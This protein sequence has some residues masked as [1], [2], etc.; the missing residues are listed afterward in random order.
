M[1]AFVE[2]LNKL[3]ILPFKR[4]QV[5]NS[6]HRPTQKQM[7]STSDNLFV[8]NKHQ[9][10]RDNVAVGAIYG[11]LLE[12]VLMNTDN[13]KDGWD[14]NDKCPSNNPSEGWDGR[15]SDDYRSNSCSNDYS[16]SS[17]SSDS[18]SSSSSDSSW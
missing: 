6:T 12:Q 2:K 14:G 17:S 1:K 13:K 7:E 9:Y 8:Q 3:N 5:Q 15:S 4:K 11:H 16:S 18:Y 10:N